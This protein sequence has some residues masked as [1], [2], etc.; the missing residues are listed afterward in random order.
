MSLE[1]FEGE[2][3]LDISLCLEMVEA[4][5]LGSTVDTDDPPSYQESEVLSC[6]IVPMKDRN[7]G[8]EPKRVRRLTGSLHLNDPES[9]PSQL[10]RFYSEHLLLVLSPQPVALA[11]WQ[12]EGR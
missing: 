9:P 2:W 6:H 8:L 4:W 3:Q 10:S 12:A 11:R 5:G 1:L 7:C